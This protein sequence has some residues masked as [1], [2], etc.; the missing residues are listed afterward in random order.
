[1]LILAMAFV[2][3]G[4]VEQIHGWT[5][6]PNPE[7]NECVM[8]ASFMSGG[9]VSFHW[10]PRKRAGLMLYRSPELKSIAQ[11]KDYKIQVGF[12]KAGKLDMGWSERAATGNVSRDGKQG[13]MVVFSGEEI[14]SDIAASA[15]LGF[16]YRDKLVG[17]VPLEGSA[18]AIAALR[19]CEASV[20]KKR[21]RDPFDE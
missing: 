15:K 4:D 19:R 12:L 6:F 3:Q 20:L 2:A 11:G 18:K 8:T 1:M 21:R 7:K 17:S 14:L 16:W 13:F 5:V 10:R 9:D